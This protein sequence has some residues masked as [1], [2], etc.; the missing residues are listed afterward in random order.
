MS[1]TQHQEATATESSASAHT[2]IAEN[3]K[4]RSVV[5][6]ETQSKVDTDSAAKMAL[7][8]SR[9]GS[10]HSQIDEYSKHRQAEI[11]A[12]AQILLQKIL[13]ETQAEQQAL[14]ADAQI[15]CDGI[16]EQYKQGLQRHVDQLD[17]EKRLNALQEQILE[18]ARQNIDRLNEEAN[19]AKL[20]VLKEAQHAVNVKVEEITDQAAILGQED[21]ARQLQSTTTTVITTQAKSA[22]E[23]HVEGSTVLHSATTTSSTS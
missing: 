6:T 16:E 2:T 21:A 3:V 5:S 10:T 11:S 13:S 14:I 22:A 20:A 7:L 18:Q 9:L 19:A 12:E 17:L 1:A 15:R 8:M 4:V 23:T